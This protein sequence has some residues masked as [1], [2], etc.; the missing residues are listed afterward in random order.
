MMQLLKWYLPKN[1]KRQQKDIDKRPF[2]PLEPLGDEPFGDV[3]FLAL[4]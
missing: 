2:E 1:P 3:H 4:F